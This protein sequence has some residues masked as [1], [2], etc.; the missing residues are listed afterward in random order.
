MLDRDCET[1]RGEGPLE[2]ELGCR[3]VGE[4]SV[5]REREREQK[6]QFAVNL[7]P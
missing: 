6:C 3:S 7:R 2:D 5:Q 1:G 4:E